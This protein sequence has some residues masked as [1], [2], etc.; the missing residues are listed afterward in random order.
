MELL[1]KLPHESVQMVMVH[2]PR[3]GKVVVRVVQTGFPVGTQPDRVGIAIPWTV[4]SGTGVSDGRRV[5]ILIWI[6][7]SVKV[8]VGVR[9]LVSVGVRVSVG[10]AERV[11]VGVIVLV[12]VVTFFF[13]NGPQAERIRLTPKIKIVELYFPMFILPPSITLYP[14]SF[15]EFNW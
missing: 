10:V 2:V 14:P 13:N 12:G 3:S 9:V 6:S 7:V 1:V 4:G 15:S 5:P 11:E 8:S